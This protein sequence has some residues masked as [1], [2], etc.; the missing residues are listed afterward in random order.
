MQKKKQ[1][2]MQQNLSSRL[3]PSISAENMSSMTVKWKSR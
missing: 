2:K 1:L 3:E